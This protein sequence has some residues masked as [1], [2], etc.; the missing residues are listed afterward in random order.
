MQGAG[1]ECSAPQQRAAPA[2]STPC[3]L[4]RLRC[5]PPPPQDLA[6]VLQEAAEAAGG[7]LQ[8]L[9]DAA[10][11]GYQLPPQFT[12]RHRALQYTQLMSRLQEQAG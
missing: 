10:T 7:R 8:R 1:A 2:A 3:G 6:E 5:A 4:P 12:P 9:E 11:A